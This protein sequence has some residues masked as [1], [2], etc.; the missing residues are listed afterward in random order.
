MQWKLGVA[1]TSDSCRSLNSTFVVMSLRVADPSGKVTTRSF[2]MTV[3]EFK[4]RNQTNISLVSCFINVC[5][6]H[7]IKES[8]TTNTRKLGLKP[9]VLPNSQREIIMTWCHRKLHLTCKLVIWEHSKC[10]WFVNIQIKK[11]SPPII[12]TITFWCEQ[13]IISKWDCNTESQF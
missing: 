4:V 3:A 2:E 8:S 5:I 1:M 13:F 11:G 7:Q 12:Q 10:R 9:T 6:L